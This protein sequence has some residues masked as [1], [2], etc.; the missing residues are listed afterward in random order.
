MQV[1]KATVRR[2]KPAVIADDVAIATATAART[3]QA[4]LRW[5]EV[6][7]DSMN[8]QISIIDTRHNYGISLGTNRS[9]DVAE[10]YKE[11]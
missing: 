8:T 3:S 10:E 2:K 5:R 4:E 6:T 1:Q 7:I 9:G 11:E